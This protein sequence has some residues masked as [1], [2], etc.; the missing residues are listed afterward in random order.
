MPTSTQWRYLERDPLSSQR[1]LSIKGRRIKARTLAGAFFNAEEPRT[2]EQISE[3][4]SVPIEAV[5]EAIA[6]VESKPI[7]LEQDF[8]LE[9]A[10]VELAGHNEPGSNGRAIRSIPP[11]VVARLEREIYGDEDRK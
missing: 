3:D 8:R 10:L 11:E 5:R 4:W 6:Y 9:E 7:E 2:I 1:Q